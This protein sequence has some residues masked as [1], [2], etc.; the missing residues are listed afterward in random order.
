M[1]IDYRK[2]VEVF[3][4]L[5]DN[6]QIMENLVNHLPYQSRLD[7]WEQLHDLETKLEVSVREYE[8]TSGDE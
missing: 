8:R 7:L 2:P 6:M 1:K 5:L 4:E 3:D